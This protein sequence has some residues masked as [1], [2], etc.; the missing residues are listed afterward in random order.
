MGTTT[1]AALSALERTIASRR[2][3]GSARAS[4]VVQL[5][6]GGSPAIHA[7][8]REE[9]DELIAAAP[10]TGAVAVRSEVVHEAADLVFHLLVLLGRERIAWAE[11]EAELARRAGIS[12]L[13]EKARRNPSSG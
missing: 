13:E 8:L 5:L 10:G 7:K 3:E 6:R 4:Y 1:S 12:G 2:D 11:I 9:L